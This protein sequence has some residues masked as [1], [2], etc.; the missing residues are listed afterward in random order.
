MKTIEDVINKK[1]KCV[2]AIAELEKLW[3]E[4]KGKETTENV[5]ILI[6]RYDYIVKEIGGYKRKDEEAEK[7]RAGL[8]GRYRKG[9]EIFPFCFYVAELT[10]TLRTRIEILDWFLEE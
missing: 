6:N 2:W 9:E 7:E 1:E 10:T 3:E 4:F 5:E 8:R